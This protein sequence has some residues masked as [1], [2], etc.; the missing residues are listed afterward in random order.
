MADQLDG[1]NPVT[2]RP[3]CEESIGKYWLPNLHFDAEAADLDAD[4]V[5]HISDC[6][7]GWWDSLSAASQEEILKHLDK[8]EYPINYMSCVLTH[9]NNSFRINKDQHMTR[10]SARAWQT[11]INYLY[12]H[13]VDL[14]DVRIQDLTLYTKD[15]NR[16]QR[17]DGLFCL[18]A[19]D[20]GDILS[21][22]W[23]EMDKIN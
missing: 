16:E 4:I 14:D 17:V 20:I 15:Y 10:S 7:F 22:T 6:D 3:R 18:R 23:W 2:N 21:I 13:S 9:G 12:K 1:I 5:A 11:Y 8:I 19:F